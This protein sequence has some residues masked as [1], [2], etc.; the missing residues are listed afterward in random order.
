MIYGEH[1][2]KIT[3]DLTDRIGI[4]TL[5]LAKR[6]QA[7][8]GNLTLDQID[9]EAP[10]VPGVPSGME[11]IGRETRPE[12]GGLR[13]FWTYTGVHGNGKDVTFKTRGNSP[14]YRFEPGFSQ[15][16]IALHPRI[17]KLIEDFGGYPL[18]GE[19]IFPPNLPK[20]SGGA[21]GRGVTAP[22]AFGPNYSLGLA[23]NLGSSSAK[24]NP[25]FGYT[26]FFRTEGTYFY[27]YATRN[28][29]GIAAGVWGIFPAGALPGA[30]PNYTGRNWLKVD[31][32]Y[33]RHGPVYA[34]TEQYWLSGEGGW[35]KEVYGSG[36][37]SR[38]NGDAPGSGLR[39]SSL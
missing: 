2:T 25:L 26:S 23:G 39:T 3:S 35:P 34:V 24:D 4:R 33:Q 27:R 8:R 5:V 22:N 29:T 18:D 9:S 37:G 19:I 17:A 6:W 28:I 13:T 14:D 36:G 15:V 10:A 38:S 12:G 11:F 32:A 7:S 30:A 1:P 31:P 20:G 21:N 16:P